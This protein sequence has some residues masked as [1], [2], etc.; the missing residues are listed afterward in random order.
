MKKVSWG[1]NPNSRKNLWSTKR[2]N[3]C[4]QW[5]LVKIWVPREIIWFSGTQ[6]Q[7]KNEFNRQVKQGFSSFFC[8]FFWHIWWFFK[9]ERGT[10]KK[11]SS[12]KWWKSW[13]DLPLKT[14]FSADTGYTKI[15]FR[16]PD[17]SLSKNITLVHKID[18]P[19]YFSK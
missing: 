9:V 13:F 3:F 17:L 12:K 15:R 18:L 5:K 19:K 14:H 6:N 7:L 2:R 1:K 8:Q 10:L 11:S 4:D 16:V